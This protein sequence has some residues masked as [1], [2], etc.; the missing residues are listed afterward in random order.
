MSQNLKAYNNPAIVTAQNYAAVNNLPL[1]VIYCLQLPTKNIQKIKKIESELAIFNIPLMV[2]IGPDTQT[3][4]AVFY[5]VKP[6][7][8]YVDYE[9]NK[10]QLD[11]YKNYKVQTIKK[12][13]KNSSVLKKHPIKW[14][15]IITPLDELIY[16]LSSLYDNN[17][18]ICEKM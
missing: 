13:Y 1:V 14:P 7:M 18:L 15:G 6:V 9:V 8:I 4:A 10:Q 5:H 12:T 11:I 17:Q 3:L 16:N 2:V